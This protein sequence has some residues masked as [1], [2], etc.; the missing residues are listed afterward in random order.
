MKKIILTNARISKPY[1]ENK[2]VITVNEAGTFATFGIGVPEPII[3]NGTVTKTEYLNFKVKVRD[4]HLV[5]R[6]QKMKLSAG[7][8][9]NVTGEL[10]V[11]R[12]TTRE[13]QEVK[14]QDVFWLESVE[15]A[16]IKQSSNEGGAPA[17]QQTYAPAARPQQPA[18]APAPATD[19]EPMPDSVDFSVDEGSSFPFQ[20]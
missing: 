20:F 17:K 8:V 6:V 14:N 19:W 12:Y 10:T 15:Y 16:G 18:A 4:P 2:P 13:G 5:G 9:V 7:S 1:G 11:E 3:E